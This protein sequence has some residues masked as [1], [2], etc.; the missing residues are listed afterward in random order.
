VRYTPLGLAWREAFRLAVA[1]AQA[2]FRAEV[3]E[4][5]ATVVALGLEAYAGGDGAPA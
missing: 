1:Q 3:G 2:E 4:E 5:V